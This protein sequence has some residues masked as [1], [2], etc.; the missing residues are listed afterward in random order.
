MTNVY[1]Y[2]FAPGGPAAL[3]RRVHAPLVDPTGGPGLQS[4]EAR[5]RPSRTP[6][7]SRSSRASTASTPAP[8]ATGILFTYARTDSDTFDVGLLDLKTQV[9]KTLEERILLPALFSGP[10]GEPGGVSGVP[11]RAL[12]PLRLRPGPLSQ[13]VPRHHHPV[14]AADAPPVGRVPAAP[15]PPV[16]VD[17]DPVAA[18]VAVGDV[19]RSPRPCR[20]RPTPGSASTSAVADAC[21]PPLAPASGA[22]S[23][24]PGTRGRRCGRSLD[25]SRCHRIPSPTSSRTSPG[26]AASRPTPSAAT[27]ATSAPSPATSKAPTGRCSPPSTPRSAAGWGRWRWT[28]R[29]GAGPGRWPRCAPSTGIW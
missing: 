6:N 4:G 14:R 7:R 5:P 2:D 3:P 8:T 27:C 17:P 18:R 25:R 13:P 11:G 21:I 29:R 20:W 23:D 19:D 9:R 22:P 15:R 26:P 16:P 24:S 28:M 10:D 12:R 1:G